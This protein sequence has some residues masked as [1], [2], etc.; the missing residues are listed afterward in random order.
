MPI[1]P[2]ASLASRAT[3]MPDDA[4]HP[5]EMS[6]MTRRTLPLLAACTLLV[7]AAAGP[8]R[9]AE[10]AAVPAA[11]ATRVKAVIERYVEHD[12]AVKKAF[13]L[14]DPRTG[15]ALRLTFDHVHPGA[16][17]KGS[18]QVACVDFKDAAGKV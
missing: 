1:P 9:G 3:A 7:V 17:T 10:A 6:P 8:L 13:L 2:S 16:E 5:K 4:L 18:Q 11:A 14:L 15:E 12:V